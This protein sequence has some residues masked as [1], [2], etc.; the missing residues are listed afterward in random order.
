MSNQSGKRSQHDPNAAQNANS[1]KISNQSSE[2]A[3]H[4]GSTDHDRSVRSG[5]SGQASQ[6]HVAND[7]NLEDK[8][9][10]DLESG[11]GMTAPTSEGEADQSGSRHG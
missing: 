8:V 9:A 4:A 3:Q 6:P 10:G 2:E 5:L 1:E 7:E 11:T